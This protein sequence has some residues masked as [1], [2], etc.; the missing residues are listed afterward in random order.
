MTRLTVYRYAGTVGMVVAII[1]VCLFAAEVVT[2]ANYWAAEVYFVGL[3]LMCVFGVL[4]ART[5]PKASEGNSVAP[6]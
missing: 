5:A 1:A 2:G 4:A 6:E 3:L